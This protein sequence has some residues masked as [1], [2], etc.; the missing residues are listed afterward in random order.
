[1]NHFRNYRELSIHNYGRYFLWG[2]ER[3]CFMDF[4]WAQHDR[5]NGKNRLR[6]IKKITA[7]SWCPVTFSNPM[8]WLKRSKEIQALRCYLLVYG[9]WL[10]LKQKWKHSFGVRMLLSLHNVI[11][12]DFKLCILILTEFLTSSRFFKAQLLI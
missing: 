10:K 1:M 11:S 6:S 2:K 7:F 4:S 9:S 3:I 5:T 12:N 8:Q